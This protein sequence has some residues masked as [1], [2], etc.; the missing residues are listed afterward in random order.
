MT[1]EKLDIKSIAIIGA[2]PAGLSTLYEFL[3]TNKDG[4]ST[5]TNYSKPLGHPKSEANAFDKIV[6]FEQKDSP[7][8][9]WSPAT[10]ES[11]LPIPPQEILDTELYSDPKYIRPSNKV[12]AGIDGASF[13]KP[14]IVGKEEEE[15]K[16]EEGKAL[17]DE[18]QWS[19]SGIFP[20]LFTNIPQRFTR[21]SY[22]PD[23]AIYYDT[24]R[25]IYPF[26]TH[27]E[28]TKRFDEFIEKENLL[29]YIRLNSTVEKVTKNHES[30]KWVVT[31]RQKGGSENAWYQETFDAVVIAN[32]HYTVPY[33]PHIKG[34][35]EYNKTHP[36]R[37]IHAKSFRN[38]QEF[39]D[40]DVLVIGGSISTVNILQYIVPVAK[41]VT[42]SKRGKHLVF[43]F[44]NDALIS[45]GIEPKPPLEYID[46]KTGEFYFADGSSGKYDKVVFSTG[47]H[48][49]FPFLSED[50]EE[51]YLKLVNPGNLSR[52][53]GLFHH[54][55]SQKDATLGTV[56]VCV[57]QLN[58]HTIEA[59]SAALAG[60]W[61]GAKKLP[62][63]RD[64][65]EWETQQ[66]G[67]RG[68][69]LLFHYYNHHDARKFVDLLKPF[70]P[71]GR[72]DPLVKDGGY[73]EEVDVGGLYL[74]EL[75]YGLKEGRIR[76]E[77]T[78]WVNN[79]GD[80]SSEAPGGGASKEATG[81]EA[82]G[83]ASREAIGG[84][85]SKEATGGD[86]SREAIGGDI[87]REPIREA[88][89]AVHA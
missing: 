31:I 9:I 39:K 87:S 33:F 84:E 14:L 66:V 81:G 44:I 49:H 64:Q 76:V 51:E 40:K 30:G 79:N 83:E 20:F 3:H 5:I 41:S 88:V 73:V 55:F 47:Y 24:K 43:E 21:F 35:A 67:E 50:D 15:G 38:T 57:S 72:Y 29:E 37:L 78:N 10:I 28:L 16:E 22:L 58:F 65:Q 86:A 13:D 61:S 11:D 59:S 60:V 36:G 75:F 7:G 69:S 23:E 85:A 8:G 34:L 62:S 54:T 32:G 82:I 25:K 52:V 80:I 46:P 77:E 19:R 89:A 68:D 45:E 71:R 17:I 1:N 18:L 27:Q 74:K 48:Y 26:M 53:G 63:I 2:G 12:P 42:D 56:G 6:V 4:S 70:F